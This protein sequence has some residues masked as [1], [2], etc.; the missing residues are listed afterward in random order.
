[1]KDVW[2]DEN[3]PAK[4]YKFVNNFYFEKLIDEEKVFEEKQNGK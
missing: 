1:M 4:R 2:Y 3:E